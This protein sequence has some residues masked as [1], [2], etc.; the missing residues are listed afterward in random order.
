MYVFVQYE[1][2]TS[3]LYLMEIIFEAEPSVKTKDIKKTL[4]YQGE[5]ELEFKGVTI[6]PW[7]DYFLKLS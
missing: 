3:I 4:I 6:Y 5:K 1:I 2:S 7:K